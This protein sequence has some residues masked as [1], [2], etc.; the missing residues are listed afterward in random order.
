MNNHTN[1]RHMFYNM[2]NSS[3]KGEQ[4]VNAAEQNIECLKQ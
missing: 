3:C 4:Q 2:M 1:G